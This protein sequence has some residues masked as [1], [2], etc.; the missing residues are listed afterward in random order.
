MYG[1]ATKEIAAQERSQR[2]RDPS[3]W[4]SATPDVE[5]CWRPIGRSSRTGRSRKVYISA[6][7]ILQ[8]V[9]LSSTLTFW[10]PKDKSAN[11][12]LKSCTLRRAD[13]LH[14]VDE[15]EDDR[16]GILA[17]FMSLDWKESF[18][19]FGESLSF[20]RQGELPACR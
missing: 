3:V 18:L 12:L 10:K 1:G 7:T 5:R 4:E 19:E 9:C 15:S 14:R 13:V 20:T 17:N 11:D 8:L 6:M 16:F 2:N